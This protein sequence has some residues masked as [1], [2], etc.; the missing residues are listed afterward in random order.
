M[1]PSEESGAK[2][3]ISGGVAQKK[4]D[5]VE[6]KSD[7][8][9]QMIHN[10]QKI[11]VVV[12]NFAAHHNGTVITADSAV[13]Y[14]ERH[15]ECFGNVLINRGSTYIYG[16]RADYNGDSNEAKVYSKIVKVVDGSATLYTYNFSYNTKTSIGYYTGGGVLMSGEAMLESDRGYLYSDTHEIICVDRVQMRNN[17]YDMMGDSVVYN[18]QTDF[19]QFFT[20]T[21]IWNKAQSGNRSDDDYLYADRGSFDKAK[22][23]YALTRNGYI[24]TKDQELLCDSLDYYRDSDY[25]QLKRNIQIDDAVQKMLIFGDWGEYWKE[26]GNVFVTRNPSLVSYDISQGDTLFMRSD[27][28]YV[29]THYPIR[30]Q[31]EKARRDSLALIEKRIADSLNKPARDSMNKAMAEKKVKIQAKSQEISNRFA[32]SMRDRKQGGNGE[33]PQS[34]E[35]APMQNMDQR[36]A[37]K[38]QQSAQQQAQQQKQQQAQQQ[39]PKPQSQTTTA[40]PKQESVAD[41]VVVEAKDSVKVGS[42]RAELR[43]MMIDSLASDT[44]KQGVRLRAR[45]LK[46]QTIETNKAVKL[47]LKESQRKKA[48]ER[49]IVLAERNSLY[50]RVLGEA[51]VRDAERKRAEKERAK[52]V[53]DSLKAV[54]RLAKELAKDSTAVAVDSL[55]CDTIKADSIKGDS[56]RLDS[57][58][59]DSLAKDSTAVK[60]VGE[61]DTMTVKQVKAYFKAIYDKEKAEEERIKQDS[62][63]AKLERIGLARQAKRTEQYRKWEI[64][65]SIYYAKAQERADEQLR[66]K[67]ARMERRGIYLAMADSLT[68]ARVDSILMAE[69]LPLDSIVNHRLD[70]LIEVLYPKELP[71]PTAIEKEAGPNIDSL[72]REIQAYS[73]VKIYRSDFQ[74]VCDSLAMNTVDSVMNMYKSPVMWNGASQITSEI[75]H[76]VIQGGELTKADFEGKPMMVSEIDTTHYNQVAGKE[77]TS[78]F[79]NNEIYR[80]DVNGNVQTIYYMQEDNSPE[81]TLMAYIEAGDM[82]SYIEKQ[83]VV[84]ITYRGN[85][86]YTFYPMDKIPASQPTKLDGFKWEAVRRPAQDSVFT[87]TIRPSQRIEKQT[88]NRPHFPINALLEQRKSNYLRRREW[89]DRT[90]T[91]TYETIEWLESLKP[92]K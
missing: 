91:L 87:R 31:I 82:T 74:S 38:S 65:D 13:R 60:S 17:E 72:Y 46:E 70:S 83:Q 51:K 2:P 3:S 73:R 10:G 45:L 42:S 33:P 20:N 53:K 48:E 15:I 8:G 47:A 88:M 79:R 84:G 35:V 40:T 52:F 58:Q 43:Q 78:L 80:N 75:M 28:M 21:N 29:Y 86:V 18:T 6:M 63:D 55:K 67:L 69:Y 77:M 9:W 50:V 62:L 14:S 24:L 27:S 11:M 81:I 32:S 56:V 44:T 5:Y 66:R 59:V 37:P 12:G 89:V 85:P 68:L 36:R 90:D 61:F 16:D 41:S 23:L 7:E 76:L 64:R 4:R 34:E 26:P 19:A 54:E 22:Q 49:A 71:S 25:V 1:M 39:Q 30:E 92:I 57:L